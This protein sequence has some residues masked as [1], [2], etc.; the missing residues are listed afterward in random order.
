MFRLSFRSLARNLPGWTRHK[1]QLLALAA[2]AVVAAG[3]GGGAKTT[4][5]QVVRG[6]GFRFQTPVGWQIKRT[7]HV[8]TSSKPGSDTDLVSV[9]R[10]RL[11][12]APTAGEI[13]A[14]AQQLATMLHGRVTDTRVETVAGRPARSYEL[15]YERNGQK[16]ELRL[17]FVL[18]RLREFQLLCRLA[19]PSADE[20]SAAC[21]LLKASFR[22]V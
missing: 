16:L 14:A 18:R 8:V 6:A 13:D 2:L 17:V 11:P 7:S 15:A 19:Q 5:T 21:D 1:Q 4:Q 3:C 20:T 10:Y 22:I 12:N 9:S